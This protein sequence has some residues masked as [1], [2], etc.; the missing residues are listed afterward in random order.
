M[1]TILENQTLIYIVLFLFIF[2]AMLCSFL[3]AVDK[4]VDEIEAKKLQ[5]LNKPK[6]ITSNFD[7]KKRYTKAPTK[8]K[9]IKL[10]HKF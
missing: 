3:I 5:E 8:N 9:V 1:K 4:K 7:G 10:T 2:F 6:K